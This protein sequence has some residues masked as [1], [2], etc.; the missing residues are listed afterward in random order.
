M[1]HSKVAKRRGGIAGWVEATDRLRF[2]G[3][4]P[5]CIKADKFVEK[6]LTRPSVATQLG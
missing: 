2:F 4:G 1:A 6:D 5:A 3:T